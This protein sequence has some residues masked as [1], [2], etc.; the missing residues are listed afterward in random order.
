[1]KLVIAVVHG[2]DANSC[3]DALSDAG[4]VVTRF[5]TS[6]GF[7]Q[8]GNATILTGVEDGRVDEVMGLLRKHARGRNEYMNPVPPMAEPAEF[9]VPFPVEVQVGGA[10][11]FVLDVE[12]FEKL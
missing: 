7:L 3:S 2:E 11:V 10:T 12:R 8:K 5:T 9:F 4:F 1:M 6:G